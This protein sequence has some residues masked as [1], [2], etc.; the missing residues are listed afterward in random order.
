PPSAE[1]QVWKF[2]VEGNEEA[3]IQWDIGDKI[4]KDN[5]IYL[6][7]PKTSVAIDLRKNSEYKFVFGSGESKRNFTLL[8]GSEEFV[9]NQLKGI[10]GIPKETLL[11]QNYPNPFSSQ[12]AIRYSLSAISHEPSA[13]SHTTLKIYN[14]AG[15][16]VKTLVNEP[17]NPGY[18]AVRWDGKDEAGKKVSAGVYFY[19]L[20]AGNFT[21]TRK[22][23]LLQ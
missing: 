21:A 2:T 9:L 16:L 17:Q 15:Q 19:R 20:T 13:I 5:A 8:M 4:S 23:V 14:I 6:F 3:K 1:G 7:D 10:R 18:Y 11:G 12:T 22:M